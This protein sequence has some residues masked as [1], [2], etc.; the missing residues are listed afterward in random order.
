[1]MGWMQ[2]KFEQ[3]EAVVEAILFVSGDAVSLNKIADILNEDIINAKRII[4]TL[5]NKYEEEERGIQII[6]INNAYQMC[7]SPKL[8][9]C[10]KE[11]YESPKKFNMTQA[12][13]ETLAIIAYRQPVTKAHIEE[14]RGVHCNHIINKL[15]DYNLVYEVGRMNAPGKPILF[16][17]TEDFLRYFG[18]KTISDLP[19]L[20]EELLSQMENEVNHEVKQIGLF[21][22]QEK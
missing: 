10:I 4:E 21:D 11:F 18:F 20:E 7:T 22:D 14:I 16:G 2:M 17:T 9:D 1:M 15:I 3:N 19:Q 13:L 6:E 8:F 5:M 12:A